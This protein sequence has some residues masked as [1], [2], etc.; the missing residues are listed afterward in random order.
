MKE[1]Q[2]RPCGICEFPYER[3][4]YYYGKLMTVRDFSDEQ[5]YFNEKRW[6]INR[7]VNG[8]GVVCGLDV[9]WKDS[10][11]TT[12]IVSPGMAID[13]CGREIIVC[14]PTE[15]ELIPEKD[16]CSNK[17]PSKDTDELLICLEYQQCSTEQVEFPSVTCDP[18]NTVKFN[19]IRDSYRIRVRAGIRTDPIYGKICPLCEGKSHPEEKNR[20]HIPKTLHNYLCDKLKEPCPECK[21]ACVV[22][23]TVIKK[24]IIMPPHEQSQEDTARQDYQSDI[25]SQNDVAQSDREE[26][27]LP[28]YVIDLCS[29]RRLVYSNPLLFDLI[30]CYH[31]D[32][33]HVI[34][35][36]W[37]HED[38]V[39]WK[40]FVEK[41]SKIGLTVAF[42]G[43]MKT[44]SI[45]ENTFQVF[46]V[47]MDP[48]RNYIWEQI[49][50]NIECSPYD[51]NKNEMSA[52]FKFT[53]PKWRADFIEGG[54]RVRE[55]GGKFVIVL[56]S[57]F[58]ISEDK[59]H[60]ALDGN[61]IGGKL[62]S[63]NGT[64]GGDFVSWFHVEAED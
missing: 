23:A 46:V 32:M 42:D 58:I 45:N 1:E 47:T 17:K 34:N 52:T 36:N 43:K 39:E 53:S 6:L 25:I 13:C 24:P 59:P 16:E 31:G 33:P 5:R 3:N 18:E 15:K 22:L 28:K 64:Q 49:P 37:K 62:P 63:G 11:H 4:N 20:P 54:S 61:F 48:D 38:K 41:I 10:R 2:K 55:R 14:E 19:R 29:R 56:K 51:A 27:I 26:R 30:N 35:L 12:V 44:G 7:M 40:E 9:T 57:D 8:W 50:G 60:K 21:H